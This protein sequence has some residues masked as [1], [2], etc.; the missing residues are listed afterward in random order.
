[1]YKNFL[2][3][4]TRNAKEKYKTYKNK[5]TTVIRN[6]EKLYHNKLLVQQKYS[7]KGPWK[8]L[9]TVM[10]N[11]GL[12]INQWLPCP[13]AIWAFA[14]DANLVKI[15]KIYI[16]SPTNLADSL[17]LTRLPSQTTSSRWQVDKEAIGLS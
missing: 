15:L 6:S 5:L 2:H 3:C 16:G 4:R 11:V 8:I 9:N 14:M 13:L 12:S 10:K 17:F 7:I 1:M